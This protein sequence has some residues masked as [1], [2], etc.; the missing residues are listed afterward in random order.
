MPEEG[1]NAAWLLLLDGID[2][3]SE[4]QNLESQKVLLKN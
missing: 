4:T 3:M 2:G 1:V